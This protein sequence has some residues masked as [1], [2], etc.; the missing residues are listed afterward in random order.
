MRRA[1]TFSRRESIAPSAMNLRRGSFLADRAEKGLV[2]SQR[3]R[4]AS[5]SPSLYN[6]KSFAATYRDS[7]TSIGT[8]DRDSKISDFNYATRASSNAPAD[9]MVLAAKLEKIKEKKKQMLLQTNKKAARRQQYVDAECDGEHHEFRLFLFDIVDSYA[10]EWSML[11]IIFLNALTMVLPIIDR[12]WA[13][14]IGF[15]CLIADP[16]FLSIY[17]V[18]AAM[19]IYVH[20]KKYFAGWDLYDFSIVCLSL[21]DIVGQYMIDSYDAKQTSMTWAKVLKFIR[22]LR[23]ARSMRTIRIIRMFNQLQLILTTVLNA[24]STMFGIFVLIMIFLLIYAL[25]GFQ[26]FGHLTEVEYFSDLSSTMLTL[27]QVLTLDDWYEIMT[28]TASQTGGEFH[29]AL[30]VYLVSWIV[31]AYLILL[32]LFIAVLVDNFT[33]SIKKKLTQQ[34]TEKEVADDEQKLLNNADANLS[35]ISDPELRTQLTKISTILRPTITSTE[36]KMNSEDEAEEIEELNVESVRELNS[37]DNE[38]ELECKLWKFRLLAS[39]EKNLQIATDQLHVHD[40]IIELLV[41]DTEDVLQM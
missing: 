33:L 27:S 38:H 7:V 10:F 28:A 12:P 34:S 31:I 2:S 32:N 41:D 40:K 35:S 3:A 11:F 21:L 17:T 30:F 9:A 6:R 36:E 19:K 24:L 1:S 4:R 26:W 15:F 16:I 23:V 8:S 13:L 22:T 5:V 18:E 29:V 14:Q 37:N 25:I 20:R 39:L